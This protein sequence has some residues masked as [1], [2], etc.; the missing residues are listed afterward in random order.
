MRREGKPGPFIPSEVLAQ[1]GPAR[2]TT[3]APARRLCRAT[4]AVSARAKRPCLG[5]DVYARAETLAP[6]RER[7]RPCNNGW[8]VEGVFFHKHSAPAMASASGRQRLRPGDD[9]RVRPGDNVCARATTGAAREGCFFTNT[10]NFNTRATTS[11]FGPQRLRPGH[12]ACVWATTSA[13]GRQRL[14]PGHNACVWATTSACTWATTRAPGRQHLR[15]CDDRCRVGGVFFHK[16]PKLQRSGD[17]VCVR[18]TTVRTG[19]DVRARATT[20][21]SYCPNVGIFFCFRN[22]NKTFPLSLFENYSNCVEDG[23]PKLFLLV[24]VSFS[25]LNRDLAFLSRHLL[26]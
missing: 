17:D 5:D 9:V 26:I 20:S 2:V 10:P 7:M 8:R 24:R 11:A 4:R 3:P 13:S 18:A 23:N 19:D 12:N 22:P 15:P 1:T 21:G 14:R 25:A 16:H 6:A